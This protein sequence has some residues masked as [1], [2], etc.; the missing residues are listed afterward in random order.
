MQ[1]NFIKNIFPTLFLDNFFI[2]NTWI[3]Q[4]EIKCGPY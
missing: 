4:Q 2:K 3:L 1:D